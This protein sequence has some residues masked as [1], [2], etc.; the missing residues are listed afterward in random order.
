MN[1]FVRNIVIEDNFEK[2]HSIKPEVYYQI[3][4]K[5]SYKV[6]LVYGG[7]EAIIWE[8][9]ERGYPKSVTLEIDGIIKDFKFPY[10][11]EN[12]AVRIFKGGG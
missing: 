12:E 6:K 7:K 9:M 3:I 11:A 10:L 4:D 8:L 1:E 5:N 2:M